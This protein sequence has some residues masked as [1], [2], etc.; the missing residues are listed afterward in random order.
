[1]RIL[2]LTFCVLWFAS[3]E[4][5]VTVKPN[6]MLRLEYPQADFERIETECP[7]SFEKNTE[8]IVDVNEACGMRIYYPS[9]KATLFLTYREITDN[10]LRGL[11][12]DAQKLV[13]DRNAQ[14]RGIP[15]YPFA[16]EGANTY[17]TLYEINGDVASQSKFYLTDSIQNFLV[18]ALYFE[19]KPNFDS[20]YPA[21]EYMRE[22]IRHLMET[23]SWK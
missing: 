11:L 2:I 12:A 9:M 15:Q 21:V 4:E 6:A 23:V 22:D 8:A 7:Y 14:A 18:G 3:C 19:V 5:D 16:N 20:I 10:N 17:G 1:M 13:Y